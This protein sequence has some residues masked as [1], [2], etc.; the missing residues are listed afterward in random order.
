[1]RF[2]LLLLC[3]CA[4]TFA[5]P[6]NV[7]FIVIDNVDFAYMGKCYGG[8]SLTPHLDRI[9]ERGVKF[10][11]AYA[12]TPLCVPSR[13]TCLSG[14]YASRSQN[15]AG[16]ETEDGEGGGESDAAEGRGDFGEPGRGWAFLHVIMSVLTC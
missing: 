12:T 7:V 4:A 13:Y 15:S 16:G 8:D 6:P 1:M 11:R 2:L 9:A 3:T 14:R 10:T 5:A